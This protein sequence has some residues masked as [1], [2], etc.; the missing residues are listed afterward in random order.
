MYSWPCV[1]MLS[2]K[3]HYIW[4]TNNLVRRYKEHLKWE[5]SSKRIGEWQLLG[6]IPCETLKEAR[7]IEKQIKKSGHYFENMLKFWMV[8]NELSD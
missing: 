5:Y 6:Y 1:Y 7:K 4:S 8:M 2:W 3:K